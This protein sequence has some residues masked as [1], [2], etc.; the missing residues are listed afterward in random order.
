MTSNFIGIDPNLKLPRTY[1]WNIAVEQ[2]LGAGQTASVSYVGA[3]GHR[4][5]RA[6][7]LFAPNPNFRSSVLLVKDIATSL[8]R[9]WSGRYF[10]PLVP[11]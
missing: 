8:T 6:D 1:Q 5:I 9:A 11:R 4:L 7:S 3:V 10:C 2:S